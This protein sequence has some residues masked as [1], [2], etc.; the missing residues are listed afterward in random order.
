MDA[1][2]LKKRALRAELLERRA[3]LAP[4]Q[5]EK[6]D[7]AVAERVL[8]L[9]E[10]RSC[11][12]LLSYVSVRDEVDTS[13][14]IRSALRDGKRVSVPRCEGKQMVFYEIGSLD[15]LVPGRFGIPEPLPQ[16]SARPDAA[17]LCLVP[18]LSFDRCGARVGYGGGYYDRF[19]PGF[20]GTPVGL[21]Y[22]A[23]A[24][25]IPLPAEKHDCRMALVVTDRA[26]WRPEGPDCGKTL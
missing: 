19:L 4:L 18:G 11:G 22:A 1:S 17:S 9:P 24:S 14:L 5:R 2:V 25:D 15:A 13:V 7:A 3:A 6:M 20:P 23:L 16:V 21:C 26:L 8:A 12:M 10:Y